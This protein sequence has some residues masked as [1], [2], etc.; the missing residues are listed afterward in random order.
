[1]YGL[2]VANTIILKSHSILRNPQ[3]ET[4]KEIVNM[5]IE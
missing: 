1:M 2:V 3:K 4:G 5:L